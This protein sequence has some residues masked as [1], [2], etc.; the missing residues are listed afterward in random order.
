[1]TTTRERAIATS[2]AREA[3]A[4]VP[5]RPCYFCDEPT[6]AR[7]RVGIAATKSYTYTAVCVDDRDRAWRSRDV[8]DMLLG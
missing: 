7:A 2:K 5:A 3:T 8:V 4:Q 6:K 1:M